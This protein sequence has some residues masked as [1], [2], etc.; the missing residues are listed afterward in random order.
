MRLTAVLLFL[1]LCWPAL[2]QDWPQFRGNPQL[3]GVSESVPPNELKLLWTHDDCE[4][5]D[6][7]A[8]IVA[9]VVYVGCGDGNLLALELDTGKLK[10][11][12]NTGDIIGE[13]EDALAVVSLLYPQSVEHPL[14]FQ[15]CPL[16]T[17]SLRSPT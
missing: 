5:Y 13:T 2:A 15:S 3:T 9:G 16:E 7:S 8:A 6:S 17:P 4:A 11:K 1:T 10:W 14:L 12:Y